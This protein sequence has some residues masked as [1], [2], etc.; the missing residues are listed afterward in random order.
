M[1]MQEFRDG[2][3]GEPRP[4]FKELLEKANDESVKGTHFGMMDKLHELKAKV[5]AGQ[6]NQDDFKNQQMNRIEAMLTALIL[7][8][9]VPYSGILTMPNTSHPPQG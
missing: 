1:G 8:F 6:V 5:E 7:H 3:F 9:N 4:D 2:S